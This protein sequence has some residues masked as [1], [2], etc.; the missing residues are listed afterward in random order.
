VSPGDPC[1]LIFSDRSLDSWLDRGGE[2]D[3][4]DLRRH[5]LS[6]AV[7]ILG[8]R[9]K[10]QALPAVDQTVMVLGASAGTAD[11]VALA[12][13]VETALS[14]LQVALDTHVHASLGAPATAVPTKIPIT[15]DPAWSPSPASTK[16]KV[17]E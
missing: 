3:P 12:A 10:P 13:K 5:H 16:V 17:R 7:A 14:I 6:D 15:T 11:F 2:V 9:A 8:V 4:I 1:L